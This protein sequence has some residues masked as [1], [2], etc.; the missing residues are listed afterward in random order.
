MYSIMIEIRARAE[1]LIAVIL[2]SSFIVCPTAALATDISEAY[3]LQTT[4]S[5]VDKSTYS[6][7]HSGAEQEFSF[8]VYTS[9][10]SFEI[11]S[12]AIA[13]VFK[14]SDDYLASIGSSLSFCINYPVGIYFVDTLT[15]NSDLSPNLKAVRNRSGLYLSA[16]TK[17]DSV[18]MF[19]GTTYKARVVESIIAHE[20]GHFLYDTLCLSK[21]LDRTSEQFALDLESYFNNRRARN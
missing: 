10:G 17:Y 18:A 5:L 4:F 19:I 12:D 16:S 15:L 14:Y 6:L 9:N 13:S 1:A 20:F 21:H 7:K 3:I 8:L 2:A 11:P